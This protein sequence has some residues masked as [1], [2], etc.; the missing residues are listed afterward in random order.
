MS[1]RPL[2]Y[3]LPPSPSAPIESHAQ[4]PSRLQRRAAATALVLASALHAAAPAC[5]EASDSAAAA[6][7]DWTTA[8][9]ATYVWQEKAAFPAAYSGPDSL[10]T[11]RALSYSFTGTAMLGGRPWRDGE[12]Y[13]N[14]EGAQGVP[15]S[16]L[17]GL[18][19]FTN[20]EMAR[21]ATPNLSV[22][23][24]RL[25]LRQ[26]WNEGG[27]Q[28]AVEAGLTQLA[29][30][31]DRRRWVLTAGNLLVLDVFDGNAYS[32]DP[33]TQF[34]NWSF[35]TYGAFDY[36]ADGRGYSWGAVLERYH[37]DWAVRAGRFIQPYEPNGQPLDPRFLRRFGDQ[38]ELEHAHRLDGQPGKLRLLL[39][40]NRAR[41]ARF[42]D[43]LGLAA[44]TGTVPD[45]DAVRGPERNKRGIGLGLEQAVT[46][47]LGVFA[48][49]SRADGLT[50]TY[51]FTEID[52]S[53][54]A[55]ALLQGSAWGRAQD[56]VGLAA[57]RNG[58]S[59]PRRAFLAAGGI[60]TFLG[61]GALRYRPEAVV[62]LFYSVQLARALWVTL[63]WQRIRNPGDN[64]DRGPVH[65][66]SVRLHTEF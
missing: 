14:V 2:A 48:R 5:A 7:A 34:L 52:R 4:R 24:A 46:Q 15:L 57:A 29:G 30:T 62:E 59:G 32:H 26:T 37:D 49:W 55:G 41:M 54:S 65:V 53:T 27:A 25:F 43:A 22:Y 13:L 38:L 35:M 9:Q 60:G 40:R 36:A 47:D 44:A 61:D 17:T 18:G 45:L 39:F 16:G 3:R 58:L 23:R 63:D 12:L 56:T 21:S 28:E 33:R 50:E 6:P 20:G 42:D 19:G 64:A 1:P 66:G 8:F 10:G 31:V 11:Q 51:A